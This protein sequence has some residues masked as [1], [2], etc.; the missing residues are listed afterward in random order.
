MASFSLVPCNNGHV[1]RTSLPNNSPLN[2]PGSLWL[3]GLIS[4]C[5]SNV[6]T[7]KKNPKLAEAIILGSEYY[8]VTSLTANVSMH[9]NSVMVNEIVLKEKTRVLYYAESSRNWI[10]MPKTLQTEIRK[11]DAGHRIYCLY[12]SENR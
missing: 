7:K 1:T 12:V 9:H 4:E 3:S 5:S 10:R 2:V 11:S 6:E 8:D